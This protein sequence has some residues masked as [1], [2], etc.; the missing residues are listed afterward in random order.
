ME[1]PPGFEP[2]IAALQAAA[3]PL[4]DSSLVFVASFMHLQKIQSCFLKPLQHFS[5][6]F[7]ASKLLLEIFQISLRDPKPQK[8]LVAEPSAEEYINGARSRT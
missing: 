3:L 6:I 7:Q 5:Y 4:G 1:E 8:R 2:G